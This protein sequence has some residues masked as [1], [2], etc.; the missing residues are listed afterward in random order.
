MPFA[1]G[2]RNSL[3]IRQSQVPSELLNGENLQSVLSRHLLAVEG[4]ADGNLLTSILLLDRHCERLWHGAAP[5]LPPSYCEAIDG[6]E[7][8]PNAGSCGTAAYRGCPV[9]VADIESDPLWTDYRH[10]ALAH[11][12]R[13]CWSTPIRDTDGKVIGT[14]AIYRRTIGSPTAAEIES[15]SMITD[16]VA[17]AILWARDAHGIEQDTSN[18]PY[19]QPG[20]SP[21]ENDVALDDWAERL[22]QNLDKLESHADEL[23]RVADQSV[24]RDA[25]EALRAV[26]SDCRRL[27]SVIRTR[28]DWSSSPER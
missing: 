23:D 2:L 3:Q 24:S 13:A 21:S 20:L 12:L 8:G 16:H 26:A 28:I 19:R 14:F 6:S 15:I 11:G 25:A 27:N 22:L 4:M 5:N 1:Q 18:E 7:I 17:E 9:Y 10:L